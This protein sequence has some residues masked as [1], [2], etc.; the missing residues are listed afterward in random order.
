MLLVE[1]FRSKI[2]GQDDAS[3]RFAQALERGER[4]ARGP[5]S[6]RSV[7]LLLGP[8]G[9]GKTE[10]ILEAGRF[11]YG[12]T[13]RGICRFD[14][15]EF[16]QPESVSRLLGTVA[17]PSPLEAAFARTA[18]LPSCI[19]HFDEIEKAHPDV[20]KLFLGINDA[21]RLTL[22]TG[23]QLDFSLCHLVFTSNLG[24][25]EAAA[26]DELPYE[27][28]EKNVLR[29]AEHWFSPELL[30]RFRSKIVFISLSYDA[31]L[32]L[33]RRLLRA[34]LSLQG[35]HLG[36]MLRAN[37]EVVRFLLDEG[38]TKQYGAR[39]L[40]NTINTLVGDALLPHTDAV[41]D[42]TD[43]LS[44]L[45]ILEAAPEYDRLIARAGGFADLYP[46]T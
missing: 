43:V 12:E 29:A 36:R 6:P 45:L 16:S 19:M 20:I 31:Q 23:R 1:H 35:A 30:Q 27:S 25:R 4:L 8:T 28:I 14:M 3:Q 10:I 7:S 32:S 41:A 26:T 24:G 44:M 17:Q 42:A 21:A 13:Y 33:C 38:Y 15:A 37:E 46:E 2:V 5:A 39:A 22:S 9:V 40:K 18:T 34:E 11:L